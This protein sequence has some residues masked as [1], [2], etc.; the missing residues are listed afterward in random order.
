MKKK[1]HSMARASFRLRICKYPKCQRGPRRTRNRFTPTRE[2]QLFCSD[3]CRYK[4][5]MMERAAGLPTER[6]L[7]RRARKFEKKV[8]I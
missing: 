6:E 4:N 2:H 5:W 1:R 7:V 3:S 8:G